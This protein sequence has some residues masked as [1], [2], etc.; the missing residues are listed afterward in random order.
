MS[1]NGCDFRKEGCKEDAPLMY[2]SGM[3][4]GIATGFQRPKQPRKVIT[5]YCCRNYNCV[6]A[7][8]KWRLSKA[9]S[10]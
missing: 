6:Q 7:A 9:F 2:D 8:E 4:F 3:C 5:K 1:G 10:F